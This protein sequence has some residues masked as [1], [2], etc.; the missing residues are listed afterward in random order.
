MDQQETKV[1]TINGNDI[2]F[3]LDKYID[4]FLFYIYYELLQKNKGIIINS[5]FLPR[6]DMFEWDIIEDSSESFIVQGENFLF[7][8]IEVEIRYLCEFGQ[9]VY[10][11]IKGNAYSKR[12][13]K[14]ETNLEVLTFDKFMFNGKTYIGRKK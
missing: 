1:F 5:M 11:T 12:Y 7:P 4:N 9:D 13:Y 3:N 2:V 14:H 10:V 6:C 8:V